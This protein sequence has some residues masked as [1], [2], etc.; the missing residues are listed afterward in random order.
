MPKSLTDKTL[1]GVNWNLAK[2]YGKTVLNIIVGIVLARLLPPSDFGLLT[3]TFIFIGLADLF[4]TL[5]MGASVVKQKN[6]TKAHIAT[7]TTITIILGFL[8][9]AIFYFTAPLIA[10]FYKE[11]RLVP[12]LR[13]LSVIFIVKGVTAVSYSRLVRE[14]DFKS[15]LIIEFGSYLFGYSL[16]AIVFASLGFGVWSLVIGRLAT[17]VLSSILTLRKVPPVLNFTIGKK[18]FK[19]L[20]AFGSG[21]SFSKLFDYTGNN[22]DNLLIGKL[23]N[24]DALGLYNRAYN[25]MTLP[26][27]KI[28]SG[29]YNVLFPAFAKVQDNTQSLRTAYYRTIKSTAFLLFPVLTAMFAAADFIILGLYGPKWEGAIDAFKI[30][31]FAGFLRTTLS[32]SGAIAHATGNVYKEVFQQVVYV[33]TLTIGAYFGAKYY[34]IEGVGF[35]VIIALGY[36]FVA[37]SNLSIK[38]IESNWL[39]FLQSLLPGIANALVMFITIYLTVILIQSEFG[40]YPYPVKLIITMIVGAI[41]YLSSIIFLPTFIKGDSFTWL[42]EKYGK[43][44]PNTFKN[45]YFKFNPVKT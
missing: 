13:A 21:V 41:T 26:I 12:I 25:L 18:E 42:L 11:I 5:G 20:F 3:M 10:E 38:I 31:I 16:F 36:K 40:N 7:A 23:I 43:V 37:Q 28:S 6:L 24:S 22:V 27:S 17:N 30:L 29:I 9:F 2:T 1:H 39:A 34:G 14:I 44:V 15:I 33:I 19:E 32:Y 45:I 4:S 35:A 8:I